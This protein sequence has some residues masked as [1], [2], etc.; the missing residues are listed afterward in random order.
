MEISRKR[1]RRD[2]SPLS[3]STSIVNITPLSP[4]EQVYDA[5]TGQYNPD[6]T[7][8]PLGL[9]PVVNAHAADGSWTTPEAN[10]FLSNMKWYAN[11]VDISTLPSWSGK[12]SINTQATSERGTITIERNNTPGETISMHFEAQLVDTRLGVTLPITSPTIILST[13]DKSNDSYGINIGNTTTILYNPFLDRLHEYEYKVAH[14]IIVGSAAE[15]AATIDGNAYVRN[16]PIAA[17]KGKQKLAASAYTVKLYRIN[18]IASF[19]EL[20]TDDDEVVEI[21]SSNIQLDLRL[22]E[23][24][25][26]LIRA[27][28]GTDEIAQIQ[29]GVDR[30]YQ[31]FTCNPSNETPIL[32]SQTVR[33]DKA[34]VDS[35][36]KIIPYP[37][38]IIIIKWYTDSATKTAVY[39][40][41]GQDTVFQ[42]KKTGIGDDYTNDWLEVYLDAEQKGAMSVATDGVD[43]L[44]DENNDTLIFN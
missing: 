31:S 28:I 1:I 20:T 34:Q 21:S 16:I 9:R 36:G 6:R 24:G 30:I 13:T 27:F 15:R 23:K 5:D 26:Y 8:S 7:I 19:T 40:N 17:Y 10:A 39:H 12:Y 43:I 44:T 29:F 37:E 11:G 32:A 3:V 38:N 22:I 35:E 18:S 25:N 33:I 4:T 41:E 42:I 14:G 2:Y